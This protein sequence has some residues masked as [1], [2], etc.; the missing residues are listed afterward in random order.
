M[1][2]QQ[3][4]LDLIA[5]VKARAPEV[6]ELACRVSLAVRIETELLRQARFRLLPRAGAWVEA[7]LWFCPLVQVRAATSISLLPEVARILRRDLQ[8][9]GLLGAAWDVLRR[10]HRHESESLQLEEEVAYLALTKTDVA[11][12]RIDSLFG[13]ALAA[14]DLPGRAGVPTV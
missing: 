1:L 7:E 8:D 2:K 3:E 4:A 13:R 10:V 9:A 5:S 11:M 12:E 14:I 6:V